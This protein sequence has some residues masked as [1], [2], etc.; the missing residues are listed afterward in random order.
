MQILSNG[1]EPLESPRVLGWA[2]S[3]QGW[4]DIWAGR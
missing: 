2:E 4:L 3:V 1:R